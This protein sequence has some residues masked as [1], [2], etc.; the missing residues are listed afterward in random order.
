MPHYLWRGSYSAQTWAAMVKNPQNRREPVRAFV[1]G[2]GGKLEAL[3]FAFGEDDAFALLEFPD[4]ATAAAAALAINSSGAFTSMSTTVLMTA[5]EAV[6]AMKKA[7]SIGYRP[8][9]T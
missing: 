9:G 5:E 6:E 3:Y 2:A 1:E 8:P 7:G 4:N